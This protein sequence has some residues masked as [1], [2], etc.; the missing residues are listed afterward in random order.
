VEQLFALVNEG[1]HE[2]VLELVHPEIEASFKLVPG[3]TIRGV[4]EFERFLGHVAEHSVFEVGISSVE[5]LD[6]R[7]VVAQGRLR[8]MAEDR[9][10]RDDPA[11]WALELEGGLVR[12]LIAV[13]SISEAEALL[14]AFNA[15]ESP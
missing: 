9:V 2:R 7:C 14:A 13:R 5:A 11:V 15:E 8:S 10:L 12:R 6:E 3:E 1:D 4:A